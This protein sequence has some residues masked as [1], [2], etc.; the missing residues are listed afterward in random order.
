MAVCLR[1]TAL[2][3]SPIVWNP[4]A[5]AQTVVSSAYRRIQ[6]RAPPEQSLVKSS[7][8]RP[9]DAQ[10][11]AKGLRAFAQSRLSVGLAI[12]LA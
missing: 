2:Q 3:L 8:R 7:P 11:E 4:A 10:R 1:E 12:M 9:H 6:M 5:F